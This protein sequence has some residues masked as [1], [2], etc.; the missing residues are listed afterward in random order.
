MFT[1]FGGWRLGLND[2]GPPNSVLPSIICCWN[3]CCICCW[4]KCEVKV[5]ASWTKGLEAR[6]RLGGGKNI[7]NLLGL[8]CDLV[9][10]VSFNNVHEI[11]E[12]AKTWFLQFDLYYEGHFLWPMFFMVGQAHGIIIRIFILC[13]IIQSSH[14]VKLRGF[15]KMGMACK[16]D[17]P[18]FSLQPYHLSLPRVPYEKPPMRSHRKPCTNYVQK[19]TP[20]RPSWVLGAHPFWKN[21]CKSNWESFS[22]ISV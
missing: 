15:L 4:K 2:K 21:M 16:V 5:S 13:S 3:T 6:G 8:W 10:H 7:L 17:P 12:I 14:T 9:I 1:L 20:Y 19:I 11:S 22:K 18:I